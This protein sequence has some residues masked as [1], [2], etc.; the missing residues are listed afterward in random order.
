VRE[1]IFRGKDRYRPSRS[2]LGV[3]VLGVIG[4]GVVVFHKLGVVEFL[5]VTGGL[6]ALLGLGF[7]TSFRSWTRVGPAGITICWGVGRRGRT[8]PWQEI[9]WVDVKETSG[10]VTSL[11]ARITLANGRRRSLPALRHSSTYPQPSFPEDFRRV[12]EWWELSTDPAARI[13]PRTRR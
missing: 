7:A 4:Q 11:A 6:I 9:R 3:L 13:L 8:Y 5:W 10:G 12:V 2:Q 1:L